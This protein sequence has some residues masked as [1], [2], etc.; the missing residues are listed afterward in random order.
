MKQISVEAVRLT[1]ECLAH[2]W[3]GDV[4][5]VINLL[6][7]DV[8][9][10]GARQEEFK[11][12]DEAVA[13]D[14]KKTARS[15][16]KCHLVDAEFRPVVCGTKQCAVVGRYLVTT[17][18][19]EDFM[20]AQQRCT[21]VWTKTDQGCRIRHLHISNPMGGP[22]LAKDENCPDT[23]GRMAYS[24]MMNDYRN[25]HQ[26]TIL[27][28]LGDGGSLH[29]L[30]LFDVLFITACGK[31][32]AVHTVHGVIPVKSSIGDLAAQTKGKMLP[33]HRSYLVNPFYI[34]AVQRYAVVMTNGDQ[35]PIP[36]RKYSEVR[37]A[38]LHIHSGLEE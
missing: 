4:E 22:K 7:E 13:A 26:A 32:A 38:L 9:W 16:R 23:E 33:I 25:L 19:A 28:A 17:D 1:R 34:S 24:Y 31:C 29:F 37:D 3:Q 14:L 10:V 15:I 21:F 36:V 27:H 18:S 35:L 11:I 5:R 2:F 8:V 30:N 12:G 20:Q 6:A